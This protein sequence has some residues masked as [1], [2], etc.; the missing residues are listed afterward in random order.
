MD[1]KSELALEWNQR[2]VLMDFIKGMHQVRNVMVGFC[3]LTVKKL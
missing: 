3:S 2:I 1:Y